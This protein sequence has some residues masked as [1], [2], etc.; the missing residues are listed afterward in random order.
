MTDEK[1]S[2]RLSAPLNA[3]MR[4]RP[5]ECAEPSSDRPQVRTPPWT[6][7]PMWP[8]AWASGGGPAFGSAHIDVAGPRTPGPLQAVHGTPAREPGARE[9]DKGMK[10]LR[11]SLFGPRKCSSAASSVQSQSVR[12][13]PTPPCAEASRPPVPAASAARASEEPPRPDKWAG[14]RRASWKRRS[15]R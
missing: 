12:I 14:A 7:W 9:A 4:M 11:R 13:L 2:A 15:L 6:R 3:R 10:A 1:R 5:C 8:I